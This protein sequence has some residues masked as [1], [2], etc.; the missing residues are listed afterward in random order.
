M[1]ADGNPNKKG[2]GI[3]YLSPGLFGA[4]GEIRTPDPLVRSQVLYPTELRAHCV[5]DADYA[6]WVERCQLPRD[7]QK[8]AEREGFEPSMELYDPI[9]P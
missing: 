4:P 5:G 2:L 8:M 6:D 1:N 9:L 7:W 3:I